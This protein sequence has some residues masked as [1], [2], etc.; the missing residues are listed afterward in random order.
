MRITIILSTVAF[1]IS[2]GIR[3]AFAQQAVQPESSHIGSPAKVQESKLVKAAQVGTVN[4]L[5]IVAVSGSAKK[6]SPA[7]GPSTVSKN[8]GERTA[9]SAVSQ[10]ASEKKNLP[11][12]QPQSMKLKSSGAIQGEK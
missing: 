8:V 9:Q 6:G 7:Y 10:S 2:F 11:L 5:P 1:L 3:G 4:G 12:V